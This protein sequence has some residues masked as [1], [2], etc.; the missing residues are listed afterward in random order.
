MNFKK[1]RP[2]IGRE[3]ANAFWDQVE[4]KP[5]ARLKINQDLFA[6]LQRVC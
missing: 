5:K 3:Q 4:K 6:L 2:L 1:P